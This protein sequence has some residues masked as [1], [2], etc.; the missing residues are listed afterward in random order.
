MSNVY[1]PYVYLTLCSYFEMYTYPTTV[2]LYVQFFRKI[3]FALSALNLRGRSSG[4]HIC[5]YR[6]VIYPT[7]S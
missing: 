5:P 7:P 3:Y 2:T 1:L 6:H 4:A